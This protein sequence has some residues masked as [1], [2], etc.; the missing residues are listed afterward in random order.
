MKPC[1]NHRQWQGLADEILLQV[2]ILHSNH[3]LA[4][5]IRLETQCKYARCS[6]RPIV[7]TPHSAL[8]TKHTHTI[9][10]VQHQHHN[11]CCWC[12]R[13]SV[14]QSRVLS[15]SDDSTLCYHVVALCDTVVVVVVVV[16]VNQSSV[17]VPLLMLL[18][19]SS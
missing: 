19:G 3:L 2:P 15:N 8:T 9:P 10:I 1:Y 4:A 18:G 7:P 13:A 14:E 16:V 11:R 5:T 17:S 12:S 6:A